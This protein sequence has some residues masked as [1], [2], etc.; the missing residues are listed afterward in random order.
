ML[1]P[2]TI[3]QSAARIDRTNVVFI[4]R[5]PLV[6]PKKKPAWSRTLRSPTT[7]AYSSTDRPEPPGCPSSS[8]P[9]KS[10]DF[11]EPTDGCTIIDSHR[12]PVMVRAVKKEKQMNSRLGHYSSTP[13][14]SGYAGQASGPW[15]SLSPTG[16]PRLHSGKP[17]EVQSP[18]SSQRN[19]YELEEIRRLPHWVEVV[20]VP[21]L[22]G[23]TG[24]W[25]YYKNNS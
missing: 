6:G 24:N 8:H 13:I 22:R 1:D 20:S 16:F 9:T 4:S 12:T 18:S 10:T 25:S 2:R 7:P 5:T 14:A 19:S 17:H 3:R 15:S 23:S 21:G 11:R